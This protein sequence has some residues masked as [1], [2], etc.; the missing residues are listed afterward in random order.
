[1]ARLS[2]KPIRLVSARASGLGLVSDQRGIRAFRGLVRSEGLPDQEDGAKPG[3]DAECHD[4]YH[5]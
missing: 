3:N 1:V 2:L 5:G 4:G